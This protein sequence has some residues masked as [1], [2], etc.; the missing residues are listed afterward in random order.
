[1][2]VFYLGPNTVMPLASILAAIVGVVL[3]FWRMIASTIRRVTQALFRT[4][5][6]SLPESKDEIRS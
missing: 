5:N 2:I 3:I 4:K 6:A 1:M